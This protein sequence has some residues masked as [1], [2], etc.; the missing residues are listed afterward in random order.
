MEHLCTNHGKVLT[1]RAIILGFG[2]FKSERI[3]VYLDPC[4]EVLGVIA[5]LFFG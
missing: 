4:C 2:I 3:I 1:A 5:F